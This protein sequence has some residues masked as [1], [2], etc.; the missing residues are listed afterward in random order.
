FQHYVEEH[1]KVAEVQ[2]I[3]AQPLNAT[4]E[5]KIASAMEKDWLVKLN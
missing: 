3:S 1:Q 4:Q 2:V 5:Q